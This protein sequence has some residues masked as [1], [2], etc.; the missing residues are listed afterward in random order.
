M[1]KESI[2]QEDITILYIY[3]LNIKALEYVKQ[4]LTAKRETVIQ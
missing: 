2:H 3:A 1:V 4:N